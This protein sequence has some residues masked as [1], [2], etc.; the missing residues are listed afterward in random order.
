MLPALSKNISKDS[1]AE[2]G[3]RNNWVFGFLVISVAPEQE[4][5]LKR[6]KLSSF[7]PRFKLMG[8]EEMGR[9]RESFGAE[10]AGKG[11]REAPGWS[12][13]LWKGLSNS[14]RH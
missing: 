9:N 4:R 5:S 10:I 13:F 12:N 11:G 8:M 6:S 14:G 3:R 1:E 7:F 2:K